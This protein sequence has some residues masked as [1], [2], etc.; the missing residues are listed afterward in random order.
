MT[1]RSV[2]T[3]TIG[4]LLVAELELAA[5]PANPH[6]LEALPALA[7]DSAPAAARAVVLGR[8]NRLLVVTKDGVVRLLRLD[9][10]NGTL[11]ALAETVTL[12]APSRTALA[13]GDLV[14]PTDRERLRAP[15]LLALSQRTALAY[16]LDAERGIA[17]EP[18]VLI[19]RLAFPWQLGQ[20]TFL[21]LVR[22]VNKDGCPDILV[23]GRAEVVVW[24]APEPGG[25]SASTQYRPTRIAG[26]TEH[27][28][29]HR[30]DELTDEC[31][32]EAGIRMPLEDDWNGDG[33]QD[34]VKRDDR[35]LRCYLLRPDGSLA[36]KPDAELDLDRILDEAS[37]APRNEPGV[38]L[39]FDRKEVRI[40]DL[41]GDRTPDSVVV[42]RNK[43]WVFHSGA[44]GPDFAT[45]RQ[46]LAMDEDCTY[47]QLLRCDEDALPDLLIVRLH[48]PGLAQILFGLISSLDVEVKA[49]AYRNRGDG[50]FEPEP[51]LR[52]DLVLR[53]P[54][55]LTLLR[56][57]QQLVQRFENALGKVQPPLLA[58]LNGD[59]ARD[60]LIPNEDFTSMRAWLR[61]SAA[62][63]G[64]EP[65]PERTV[66]ELV[67]VEKDK[68]WT[69][70]RFIA[71]IGAG[72]GSAL[73]RIGEGRDPDAVF[74]LRAKGAAKLVE[75]LACDLDGDGRAEVVLVY[76]ARDLESGN[77]LP[78]TLVD[79]VRL[80][81]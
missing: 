12:P 38:I 74:A 59:G 50:T 75:K 65:D 60:V 44:S 2:L 4:A 37:P 15:R 57:S 54:A 30:M 62:P 76:Q 58:D 52:A 72:S 19:P 5:Q 13:V 63:N 9:P 77:L 14:L 8:S 69:F 40:R 64:S 43:V 56:N 41:N 3:L 67:F 81:R 55:L 32:E 31:F 34:H 33:R 42:H 49:L 21:D 66:R 80:T 1:G 73:G 7:L 39:A 70:D 78:S 17:R 47:V 25:R 61:R 46:V 28:L 22:D 68:V 45:P 10:G 26:E 29:A 53:F 18:L 27:R 23:P 36:N 24:I 51:M 20:P 35:F 16:E 79:L 48:I 11:Q 6:G 71:W